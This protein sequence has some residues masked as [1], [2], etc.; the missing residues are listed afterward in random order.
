MESYLQISS[1]YPRSLPNM[2]V[3]LLGF[4]G[5]SRKIKKSIFDLFCNEGN[6]TIQT[7]FLV[8]FEEQGR[9]QNDV[10]WFIKRSKYCKCTALY[11]VV[12]PCNL[13]WRLFSFFFSFYFQTERGWNCR[14]SC[15]K[16]YKT[17]FQNADW[18]FMLWL[19]LTKTPKLQSLH[20]SDVWNN[21]YQRTHERPHLQTN[22]PL[23][24]LRNGN[25]LVFRNFFIQYNLM[26]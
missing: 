25:F 9:T 3:P 15:W 11:F 23:K 19:D 26:N 8:C 17:Q 24:S 12:L 21:W 13:R 16:A 18:V 7:T 20:M 6:Y 5:L 2:F 4:A 10:W 1:P 14:M 22:F